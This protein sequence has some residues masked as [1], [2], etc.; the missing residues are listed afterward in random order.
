MVICNKNNL[1]FV[2]IP[3]TGGTTIEQSLSLMTKNNWYEIKDGKA[4]QHYLWK[5]YKNKL[6]NAKFKNYFKFSICRNPYTRFLSEYYWCEIKGFGH[7]HN[8]TVDQF[9][10]SVQNICEK[11][12]YNLS[13]FHDHLLPQY[14]FIYDDN[15]VLKIDKLFKFEKFEE[16]ELFLKKKYIMKPFYK[17]NSCRVRKKQQI[18]LTQIQKNKIYDIYQKDFVLLGYEK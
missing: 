18:Q 17:A 5:N 11:K 13:I 15:N 2:H 8:Q 7:R 14:K 16:I 9:I 3:K 6:P 4:C 12:Q 1:I 10:N